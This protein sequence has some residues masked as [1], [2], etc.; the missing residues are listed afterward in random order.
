ME[1]N[2]KLNSVQNKTK[3]LERFIPK[4]A[5][6]PLI[7]CL[8]VN[9][10]IYSGTM[11]LCSDWK[12]YDFTLEIDRKVPFIP[13]FI[14][15]Y[16]LCYIFW[17]VNYIMMAH[18]GKE[19]FYKFFVA[20][21]MSRFVCL[22]FYI[23]LPT[24][25]VRP[26]VVGTDFS[27]QL[28]RFLYEMDKPANLF[29]SIHCLV[30]WFCYIGIRGRKEIPKWYQVF[31]CVVAILVFISTQVTK[32]HYIVD[33]V[34]GVALAEICFWI[35]KRS[36]LYIKAQQLFERTKFEEVKCKGGDLFES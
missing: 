13:E 28:V 17:V 27:S 29:P 6:L 16:F 11:W 31:S 35:S 34:G 5:R 1:I 21:I 22:F 25:N 19:S 30:S 2:K 4:Y 14:Y 15:I 32:Q 18:L 20:D 26:E 33:V 8:L 7:C 23:V 36:T 3:L 9:T 10:I 24:T 12:H